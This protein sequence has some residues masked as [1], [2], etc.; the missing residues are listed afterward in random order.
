PRAARRAAHDRP[1]ARHGWRGAAVAARRVPARRGRADHARRRGAVRAPGGGDRALRRHH[2]HDRARVRAVVRG[3]RR[4]AAVRVALRGRARHARRREPRALRLPA[5]RRQHG[6]ATAPGLRPAH[7]ARRP[8]GTAVRARA[9]VRTGVRGDVRRRA[10]RAA[11]VAGRGADPVRGGDGGVEAGGHR[12]PRARLRVRRE[13]SM[14][15]TSAAIVLSALLLARVASADVI[16]KMRETTDLG[17]KKPKVST[18]SWILGADRLAIRWD[19]PSAAGHSEFIFRGDKE[20]IWVVDDK[21]KS[22]EQI[23]KAFI[24][25]MSAQVTAA[26]AE[27]Q[28]RIDALPADQRAQAEEM[29]KKYAGGMQEAAAA[30]KPEYRKMPE[31]KVINGHACTKVDVYSGDDL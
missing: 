12:R 10:L 21:T 15:T 8:H 23:D 27:M 18:G 22:Y 30:M 14:R 20:L 4:A 3:R 16:L 6:G 19:D 31:S 1:R 28:A 11:L 5:A 24:D 26:K 13:G 29:M 25:Q 17:S 2:R 9:G 7:A